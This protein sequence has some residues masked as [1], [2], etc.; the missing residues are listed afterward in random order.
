[1]P[2]DVLIVDDEPDIRFL[3]RTRLTAAGWHVIGEAADGRESVELAERLQPDVILLD[4]LMDTGGAEVLPHLL[5]VAPSS[6]VAV[7]SALPAA[8]NRS[9]LLDLGAFSY[10]EKR[11][12]HDLPAELAAEYRRFQEGLA[13]EDDVPSWLRRRDGDG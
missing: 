6:M 1:M 2:D 9:R 11:Q 5:T 13:G 10:H 7:F 3:V 8:E 4:L 12:L